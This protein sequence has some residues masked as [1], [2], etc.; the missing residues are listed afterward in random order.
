MIS[1]TTTEGRV[2]HVAVAADEDSLLANLPIVGEGMA[3]CRR[4]DV[5]DAEIGEGIALGRAIADFGR[6]VTEAFQARVVTKDEYARVV[7]HMARATDVA[8]ITGVRA[9]DTLLVTIEAD[10]MHVE[11]IEE[12]PTFQGLGDLLDSLIAA[13]HGG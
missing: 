2:T 6:Q 3:I 7:D 9:G 1:L 8:L 13:E 5:F 4:D 12:V 10:H 11:A